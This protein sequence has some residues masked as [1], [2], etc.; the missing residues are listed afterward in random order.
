MG[1]QEIDRVEKVEIGNQQIDAQM[2]AGLGN[3]TPFLR[4]FAT[5]L[6]HNRDMAADLTQETLAKA[7]RSRHSFIPG[8][9]LKAWLFTI[10]RNEFSS[11]Q[12]RAWRQIR[13]D[14]DLG[15]NIPGHAD[16]QYWAV[17]LSDMAGAMQALPNTQ[18]EALILVGAAGFTYEEV[19]EH[20]KVAVGTVKSRVARGRQT[21][22][23]ILGEPKSLP[24]KWRPAQGDAISGI[25]SQLSK[26]VGINA[27][28]GGTM[29]IPR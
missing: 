27:G 29:P 17:E 9:N 20:T 26:I 28:R 4:A 8:S 5:S 24:K 12:R 14:E 3:L 15:N 13:W 18:R 21:L 7:W 22:K 11:Q 19:A 2:E 10:L 23:E 16:G 6:T 1:P 25:L